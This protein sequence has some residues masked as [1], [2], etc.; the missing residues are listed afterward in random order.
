MIHIYI[1]TYYVNIYENIYVNMYVYICIHIIYHMRGPG[2][3]GRRA[4]GGVRAAGGGKRA[5]GSI[6]EAVRRRAASGKWQGATSHHYN[7]LCREGCRRPLPLNMK[8]PGPWAFSLQR[9]CC[10][11]IERSASGAI[12]Q[13]STVHDVG[14]SIR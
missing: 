9:I 8:A 1:Y 7:S 3:D 6:I 4:A 13:R 12:R 5:V 10:T 2:A 11:W 14:L